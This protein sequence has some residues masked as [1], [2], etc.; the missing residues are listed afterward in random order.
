MN[1]ATH[2]CPLCWL[3]SFICL[4]IVI[5]Y[6]C[7]RWGEGYE[8][9]DRVIRWALFVCLFC[10]EGYKR[11]AWLVHCVFVTFD[12][13]WDVVYVAEHTSDRNHTKYELAR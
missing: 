7:F 13:F 12:L 6:F 3:L 1:K 2:D 9:N 5:E 10:L 4:Y 8:C 11:K